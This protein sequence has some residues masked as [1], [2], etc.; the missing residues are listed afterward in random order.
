M[1]LD[2]ILTQIHGTAKTNS[3][4]LSDL[5]D[6][7]I[8][9]T[10]AEEFRQMRTN[11]NLA[12]RLGGDTIIIGYTSKYF[13]QFKDHIVR[14]DIPFLLDYDYTTLIEDGTANETQVLIRSIIDGVKRLWTG[15]DPKIQ[16]TIRKNIIRLLGCS[17]EFVNLNNQA[18]YARKLGR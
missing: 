18:E 16:A 7:F 11:F 8:A 15:N 6:L 5:I 1:S 4:I 9:E 2:K 10:G 14:R 12:K 13:I 17:L 3:S